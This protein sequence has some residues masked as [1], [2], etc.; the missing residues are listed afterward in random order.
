MTTLPQPPFCSPL[1]AHWPL[2]QPL[3][4]ISL[5]STGFDAERLREDDFNDFGLAL[6]TG[7]RKR[8]AEFLAGRLCAFAALQYA[9]GHGHV[10]PSS[11]NRAPCWPSRTVGSITHSHGW[12]A[13]VAAQA[14][15]WRSLGID[16][17][18]CMNPERAERLARQILTE[19][20]QAD[21]Q[22]LSPEAY[23]R[24]LTLAF[25]FKES[26][27]KALNPLVGQYFHFQDAELHE[28]S[29]DGHARLRLLRELAP[30][31]PRGSELP[32]QFSIGEERILTLVSVPT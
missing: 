17:E 20:E 2:P 10:L 21:C 14:A 16:A 4:G 3:P 24:H 15:D 5:V 11:E 29:E 18:P 8:Q 25:S 23:A 26:L 22:G 28:V 32:G 7:V 12:A 30:D 19:D 31:W 13:A 9:T 27:F 1:Q 6:P